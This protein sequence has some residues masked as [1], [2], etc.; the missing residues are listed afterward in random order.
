MRRGRNIKQGCR[1]NQRDGESLS[2]NPSRQGTRACYSLFGGVIAVYAEGVEFIPLRVARD[3]LPWSVP[4]EQE[5]SPFE[6]FC[7]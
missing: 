1:E 6:A 5:I 2:Q 3:E 7:D 4:S